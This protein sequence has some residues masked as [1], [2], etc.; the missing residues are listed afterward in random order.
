MS[1]E[2]T[3]INYY[4]P[5]LRRSSL[6]LLL[7]TFLTSLFLIVSAARGLCAPR[8][9]EP[10]DC[11]VNL[12]PTPEAGMSSAKPSIIFILTDDM[13]SASLDYMPNV[14]KL[15][16]EQGITFSHAF[17]TDSLCCPSRTSILRSQYVHNHKVFGNSPPRGGFPTFV[18]RGNEKCNLPTW[19]AKGALRTGLFGKYLNA[20]PVGRSVD[21]VP[22]SWDSWASPISTEQAYEGY[23]YKLNV[24][25]DLKRYGRSPDDYLTDV[26][27]TR[28][29]NFI[30][31]SID[32]QRP[33]FLYLAPFAP[34]QPAT[35]AARHQALFPDLIAPRGGSFN[36]GD[37]SDKPQYISERS[38][39]VPPDFDTI[40][41]LYRK[42]LRSLQAVDEMVQDLISTLTTL[43][44]LDNTYIV[45]TSD[46]GFHLG[47]HRLPAGKETP[48]EE[49]IRVPLLIRGPNIPHGIVRDQLVLETD[50]SATFAKWAG[51]VPPDFVEGRDLTPILGE[52]VDRNLTWRTALLIEHYTAAN[53]PFDISQTTKRRTKIPPYFAMRTNNQLYVEYQTGERELYDLRADP[54]E[55]KNIYSTASS[56]LKTALSSRL[57]RLSQCAGESCKTAEEN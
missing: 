22:P 43:G 11:Q 40:D 27:S 15:I 28:A 26:L 56:E 54:F 51:V 53:E 17:V 42:R 4:L 52:S 31:S 50:L 18:R 23:G 14:M 35:P 49:D 8:V 7:R 30:K 3:F 6:R 38:L 19:L 20:Y 1:A 29:I 25:G 5:L 44:Q 57:A 16:G 9:S 45:F 33:Y 32:N 41:K 34:H 39:L 48:Y 47:Q 24:D 36:E 13:D 10:Q 21:Y 37:V 55:L 46:N 2:V 12:L